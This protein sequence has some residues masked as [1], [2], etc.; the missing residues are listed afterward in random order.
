MRRQS[1]RRQGLFISL[2][3]LLVAST[4]FLQGCTTRGQAG[5]ALS[6]APAPTD[7]PSPLWQTATVRIA[8]VRSPSS[9]LRSFESPSPKADALSPT[10]AASGSVASSVTPIP[11]A[12]VGVPAVATPSGSQLLDRTFVSAAL[13]REMHY[14]IY[15]PVGYAESGRRYPTLYMLHGYGGSNTEWIG[16]GLP[17]IADKMINAG[18]IPP[19]II[20]LPQ[21][22]QAYWVN[23]AD[24]G[25][26]WGDYTAQDVVRQIDSTYRTLPDAARR[27]VGGLSMGSQGAMQLAMN[28]PGVFGAVGMHSP[29]LRD[30]PSMSAFVDFFGDEAYFNAHDP[31]HLAQQYPD[32]ARQLKI[33]LDVGEQ[34]AEWHDSTAAFHDTLA[35]LNIPH[36]WHTW[37]GIHDGAY[38]SEHSPDYL[39]FYA[40]ALASA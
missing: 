2:P 14:F 33:F 29:T 21:G 15:L 9:F 13:G 8:A 36:E 35:Q 26:R 16:Y 40:A 39:R 38:W 24:T 28:Y 6:S 7:A 19:M 17:E 37:P 11:A 20:V 4:F 22:D 5:Q 23:H 18:A 30:Y 34:D 1:T 32:R 3:L 27:A 12:S 10:P 31:V 25:E